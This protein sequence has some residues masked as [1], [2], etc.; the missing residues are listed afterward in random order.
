MLG[1][2]INRHPQRPRRAAYSLWLVAICF[3]LV[4]CQHID[5]YEKIATIPEHNWKSNFKPQFTF[6]ISDT[7]AAYQVY[8]ILR[9]NEKYLYNN[10]W[11]NLTAQAPGQAPQKFMLELPL[12]TS[13]KG[14]LGVAMDDLYEHRLVVTLDESKLNFKKP[15]EYQFTLE[16]V[17]RDDPLENVLNVGLRIE[18]KTP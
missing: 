11:L 14:W 6:N 12:A 5:L 2:Q 4:A 13:A 1:L 10:I 18:K 15:G 7:S 3:Q 9:H 17:M 16:Q 8:V